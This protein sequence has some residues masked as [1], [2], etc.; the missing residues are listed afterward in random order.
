MTEQ[1]TTDAEPEAAEALLQ[2][3]QQEARVLG[4]LMEKE[5]STPEAYP[6]TQNALTNACNQKSSR[7]PVMNMSP[8]EVGHTL[9]TLENRGLVRTESGSRSE[10]YSQQLGHALGLNDKRQALICLLLLRGPQTLGELLTRSARLAEFRDTEELHLSVLKLIERPLPLVAQLARQAGQREDRFAHLLS[11]EPNAPVAT[12]LSELSGNNAQ[13]RPAEHSTD[14]VAEL[15]ERV[16]K[17][18]QALADVQ[19]QLGIAPIS[20]TEQ[21]TAEPDN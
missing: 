21:N 9:R 12:T 3:E 6:L 16:E 18:E 7:E 8:G 10:R 19:Q 5:R 17:L 20:S 13:L 15:R 11:G 4:A 14:E 2:L 1:S